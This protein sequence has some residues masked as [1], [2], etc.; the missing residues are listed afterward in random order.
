MTQFTLS[1]TTIK[2]KNKIRQIFYNIKKSSW[3]C[4]LTAFHEICNEGQH[5]NTSEVSQSFSRVKLEKP[6]WLFDIKVTAADTRV[7]SAAM[8][9][10]PGECLQGLPIQRAVDSDL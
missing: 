4:R 7:H 8:P 6:R 2:E 3:S 9:T 5:K 10:K 1:I